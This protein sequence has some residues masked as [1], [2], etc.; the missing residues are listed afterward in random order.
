MVV[1]WKEKTAGEGG[2]GQRGVEVC[3][4]VRVLDVMAKVVV[5]ISD[6]CAFG[7][8]VEVCSR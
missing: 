3:L 7:W 6:S 1:C 5:L 8:H 4:R 2:L